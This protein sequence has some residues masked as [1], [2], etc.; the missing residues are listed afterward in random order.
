LSRQ[1]ANEIHQKLQKLLLPPALDQENAALEQ[2]RLS[3]AL[4][5]FAVDLKAW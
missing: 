1:A 3:H 2:M 5:H 4:T